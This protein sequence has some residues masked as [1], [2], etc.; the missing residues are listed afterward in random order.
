[1]EIEDKEAW[2]SVNPVR[3]TIIE[4]NL[5][6]TNLPAVEE[7]WAAFFIRDLEHNVDGSIYI[8]VQYMGA[9][10]PRI[11]MQLFRDTRVVGRATYISAAAGHAWSCLE[12][13]KEPLSYMSHVCGSGAWKTSRPPTSRTWSTRS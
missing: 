2:T 8:A 3:G 13:Q 10:R 1:M 7:S 5:A 4:V 6:K 12:K 11:Q 9:Q